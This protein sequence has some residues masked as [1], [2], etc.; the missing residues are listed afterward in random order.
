MQGAK[1]EEEKTQAK[2][3]KEEREGE[4]TDPG[5]KPSSWK[6]GLTPGLVSSMLH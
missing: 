2:G 4:K 1:G 6:T 3:E 5:R